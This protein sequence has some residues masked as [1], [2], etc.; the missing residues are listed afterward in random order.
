VFPI[1][2]IVRELAD[3]G[4]DTLVD[5]AH[6]LG[7]VP[8]DLRRIGAA[9]YTA[10]AHKWLCAPKG[11]AILHVREDRRGKVHPLV[12]S[13]GFDPAAS[14]ARFV[15]EFGWTGTTDPTPW[16]SVP[17]CIRYMASVV[18]GGWPALMERNRALAIRARSILAE[19]LGTGLPCPVEMIGA[20]ASLPLPSPEAGSPAD[21]LDRDGLTAW[22]RGRGIEGWFH[23]WKCAGRLVVR[24]SAQL[25]N[26]ESDYRR[27]AAALV[28]AGL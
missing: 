3:R 24:I 16:L 22:V 27:L 13:H 7:M 10:N 4:V 8:L 25:Y 17:E 12:I 26:A 20:T 21:R 5:G 1:D 6:A 2:R 23:P 15:E 9:Y 28:D 18:P 14:G 11:A 19:S